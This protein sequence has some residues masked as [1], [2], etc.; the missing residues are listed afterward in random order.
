[1]ERRNALRV[2]PAELGIAVLNPRADPVECTISN[3][4]IKGAR[5]TFP[6]PM[7]L[8]RNF[9]LSFKSGHRTR[10]KVIWQRE[11]SAGVRF[12]TPLQAPA[13]RQRMLGRLL[14]ARRA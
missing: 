13:K 4:S 11:T 7:V 8:P 6:R 3:V 10:V 5:L 14:A 12:E 2:G 9:D 1:M